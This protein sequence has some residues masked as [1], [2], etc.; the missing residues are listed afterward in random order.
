MESNIMIEHFVY[1]R[2]LQSI[3]LQLQHYSSL[4]TATNG[5][6]GKL[7]TVVYILG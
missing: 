3:N 2:K 7:C 6:S 1:T 5:L 4:V